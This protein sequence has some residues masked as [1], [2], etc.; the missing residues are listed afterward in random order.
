VQIDA[1]EH[2]SHQYLMVGMQQQG[3]ARMVA[4]HYQLDGIQRD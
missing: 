1:G 3:Q 2:F 4:T